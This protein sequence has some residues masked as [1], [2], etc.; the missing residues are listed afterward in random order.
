MILRGK[1]ILESPLYRGNARKTLFTRDGDGTQRLVS[2]AGEI[3]GTAQ[4]L[5]DAFIGKSRDGKNIGLLNQ[6]WYRLYGSPIPDKLI[7]RVECKL[8]RECYPQDSFF[9]L[10][11]GIKL[12]E[13]RW[14]A[15][16]NANY[17][18]E[19]LFRNSI[20][21]LNLA[22]NDSLLKKDNNEARLYYLI[23]ELK[24]GNFWFGAGKSK[25]LGKCRLESDVSLSA[26]KTLP[27]LNPRA[28]HLSISMRF[29]AFNPL[30]VGWNWGKIDPEIPAFAAI[31]GHFLVE[32]M[33][34]IPEPVRNRLEAVIGGPIINPDDWKK[35]FASYLPR[36]L[37]VWLMENS[38]KE[39]KGW[40]LPKSAIKKLSKGKFP[41]SKK[42]LE[43]I[44]PLCETPFPDKQTAEQAIAEVM[45]KKAN[46]VKRVVDFLEERTQ[47]SQQFNRQIWQDIA[48]NLGLDIKLEKELQRKIDDEFAL[49]DLLKSACEKILPRLFQQVDQQVKLLQSDAWVD[50]EISNREN[51][52]SIKEMILEGGIKEEDWNN[53][54]YIPEG[55]KPAAWQEFKESHVQVAFRYLTTPRNL[56]KSITNDRNQIAF[57]QAYRNRA[58]QELSQPF[59]IDFRAGGPFNREISQKYGK[60][61]DTLFMRMLVWKA[62]DKEGNWEIYIPGS[63]IKGAFRKRASQILKTLWGESKKTTNVI[64]RL[65]GA[66]GRR[67]LVF[68]SDAYLLDPNI[69]EKTWCSMD[70]VKMDPRTAKPIEEAKADY[71]FAYGKD[72]LFGLKIDLMDVSENDLEALSVLNHLIMDFTYGDIPLGGEKTNGFGWVNSE[73]TKIQWRTTH[74]DG[75]SKRLFG[76]TPLKSNGIWQTFTLEGEAALAY[77]QNQSPISM[78]SH[79]QETPPKASQGFISHRAFGGYCGT[80]SLEAEILTPTCIHESGEPS[81]KIELN[82]EIIN[83]WDFFSIAPPTASQKGTDRKYALPSKSIRG[84][85]RHIYSIASDSKGT[86]PDISKLN[87]ADSLFGWVGNGP[88]QAISGRLAFSFA[89]F[90]NPQ[91]GWFKVPYPYGNW[92]HE[93]GDWKNIPKANVPLK[94]IAD[95]WRYF[96]HSKLAPVVEKLEDFQPDTVKASYFRAILPGARCQFTIRFWNLTKE[97]LQRLIWCL[98]LEGN[99]AHKI[100]RARYLGFGSLKMRLLNDSF[101]IDWEKRYSGKGDNW[102][103]PLI[104]T[105]WKDTGTIKYYQEL[106]EAL[107][108]NQI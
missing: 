7:T 67:G 50:V 94:L 25:G 103:L 29:S 11:M 85:L 38:T 92:Q 31:E 107:N 91:L 48:A 80:L 52:I 1:L 79:K 15:E 78:I 72:L 12:D 51:H 84:M 53:P 35:K 54:H 16:A 39:E 93:S 70:G 98:V 106:L 8:S 43:K 10:R 9:D 61:Y 20:F 86:S 65:F 22:I 108:V 13:D 101:L 28:N 77:F 66:Q 42:I 47:S 74:D 41:L 30:L 64:N 62:A 68:F 63:T 88:N 76:D 36:I 17:K 18:M 40:L 57:L 33:R 87:P 75:V 71:L 49:A 6:L 56:E 45:R 27:E 19:T 24:D 90:E 37:A 102:R 97:E 69:P 100:G 73:I 26:G 32:A 83:G 44:E 5:M 89:L 105:D 99:L 60:P 95:E 14:A 81:F 3:A 96:P 104:E 23:Q 4:A 58:R 59:H 34:N 2:L 55:I 82:D 21:D 46:L